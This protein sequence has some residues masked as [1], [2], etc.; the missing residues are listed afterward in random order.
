MQFSPFSNIRAHG[1]R[2]QH[3]ERGWGIRNWLP[4]V[5]QACTMLLLLLPSCW[6]YPNAGPC[7]WSCCQLIPTWESS[8]LRYSNHRI[9]FLAAERGES[10]QNYVGTPRRTLTKAFNMQ[11]WPKPRIRIDE[12]RSD[13]L[14]AGE[15]W[16]PQRHILPP[17]EW[18]R[19]CNGIGHTSTPL[20][21]AG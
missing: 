11:P 18:R 12:K 10:S 4:R 13:T 15:L 1:Y 21:A 17:G 7:Q 14:V 8:R 6:I 5:S 9:L 19:F 20:T 3:Q 2:S 16:I